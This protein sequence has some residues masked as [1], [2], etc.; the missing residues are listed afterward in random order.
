MRRT[1]RVVFA[2]ATL[3]EARKTTALAQSADAVAPPRQNLVRITL[4]THVPDQTIVGR[5]KDVMDRNRQLYNPE[6]GAQMAS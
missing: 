6:A 3:G 2:L 5:V 4:V 1:E